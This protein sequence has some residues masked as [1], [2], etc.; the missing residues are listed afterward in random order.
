MAEAFHPRTQGAEGDRY[1]S[2]RPVW[3]TEQRTVRRYK[4]QKTKTKKP[5]N[6][7]QHIPYQ[8]ERKGGEG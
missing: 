6:N 8:S 7:Y 1:L 2:S 4:K 3:S 5:S